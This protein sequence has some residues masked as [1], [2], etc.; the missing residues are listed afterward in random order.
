[1]PEYESFDSNGFNKYGTIFWEGN[2]ENEGSVV[3]LS[4]PNLNQKS[5]KILIEGIS[6][7]GKFISEVKTLSLE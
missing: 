1:M 3:K 7:D 4:I 6:A 5:V 2:I